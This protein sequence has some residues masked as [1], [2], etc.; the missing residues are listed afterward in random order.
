MFF[1]DDEEI[2]PPN[3]FGLN[4]GTR[5]TNRVSAHDEDEG[6]EFRYLERIRKFEEDGKPLPHLRHAAL[7][8]VHNVVAHPLLALSPS[9][10]AVEFHE[11]TS[12]W[13]NHVAPAR[14]SPRHTARI[15]HA[16]MPKVSK[17]PLWV[18]HNAISHV[19]IGVFPCKT[20]FDLHDWTA[21]LMNVPGWM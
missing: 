18:L 13:L 16:E 20:T 21:R 11:L 10:P 15:L 2:L 5:D 7:W 19:A 17:K 6:S 4:T 12:H 14:V 9:E 3:D 8:F 1:R